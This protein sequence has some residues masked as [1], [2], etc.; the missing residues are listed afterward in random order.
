MATGPEQE[1]H[2]LMDVYS[3]MADGEIQE[4]E[5]DAASLTDVARQVL[6]DEMARR[7]LDRLPP[8]RDRSQ[9]EAAEPMVTIRS[10]GDVMQAWLAKSSLDSAAIECRLVDDNMVRLYWGIAN[11]LGGVKLQVK[12]EDAEAALEMLDQP[13]PE[14]PGGQPGGQPDD[15]PDED[16]A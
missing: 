8:D 6:Q 7:G 14:Q 4:I 5:Q 3:R 2:R 13:V 10:F 15:Q 16:D 9:A 1:R 11:V 12:P